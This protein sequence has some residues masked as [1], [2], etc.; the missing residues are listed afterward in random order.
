M[1]GEERRWPEH[2]LLDSISDKEDAEEN[3]SSE[4]EL[5]QVPR[6]GV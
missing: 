6:T 3:K 1:E 5:E 4:A 2:L